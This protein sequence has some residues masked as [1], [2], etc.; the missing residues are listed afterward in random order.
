MDGALP[1]IAGQYSHTV[2]Y[3]NIKFAHLS[4]WLLLTG[5]TCFRLNFLAMV[6]IMLKILAFECLSAHTIDANIKLESTGLN[7]QKY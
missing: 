5:F 6:A 1:P 2:E 3:G 7:L 4:T